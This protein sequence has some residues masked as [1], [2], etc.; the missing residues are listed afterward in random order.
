[1]VRSLRAVSD[2]VGLSTASGGADEGNSLGEF[3]DLGLSEPTLRALADME[4]EE[5]TPI[6]AQAIPLLMAGRDLVAQA[7]TGTGK[8]A[9]FGVPIVERV[10]PTKR[11]PQAIVLTP[12]R[13]L[14]VQVTDQIGKMGRLRG[15]TAV[16]IYG[17]Q[18]IG[19]QLQTL[20]RGVHVIV[21]TPGRLLDHMRR[22]S[23]D[24]TSVSMIVLDEAD[25]MLDMGF[26]EDIEFVLAA[27]PEGRVTALFSATMPDPIATLAKKHMRDPES[28][29]LSRPRGL[30]VPEID[31]VY[32]MVPFPRKQDALCR[33]LDARQPVRTM[34]FC[35]TKRMV[36]EVVEGL[37]A[38]GYLA[39]GLHGDHTQATREKVLR[40]FRS[41]RIEVLVATDVAARGLDVP[42][43]SHVVNF[44]IPPDPEYYVHRIGR[45]GRLGRSGEAITFV[46]PRQMRELKVIER[47]T[48]AH[49]RREEVPTVAEVE[50]REFQA[51]EE[52]LQASLASG[53]WGRYRSMI[54]EL[55]DEH[56]PID[57]AAAAL[58]MA[59]EKQTNDR[60]PT[61]PTGGPSESRPER[62]TRPVPPE[63]TEPRPERFGPRQQAERSDRAPDRRPRRDD[64]PV[65][66]DGPDRSERSAPYRDAEPTS[67][68][69]PASPPFIRSKFAA[70]P[71][72]KGRPPTGGGTRKPH[73]KGPPSSSRKDKKR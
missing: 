30:T 24:L 61:A 29:K 5:S 57:L 34:V 1:M 20:H 14:A 4:F 43:V 64:R 8:T 72:G 33:V 66:Q 17:G 9:A 40:T 7:L 39:D 50:E 2:A 58:A 16:P 25:Q 42:E 46:N 31:Q 54:E 38:R 44:D 51:L 56:D 12:T 3:K 69:G 37:Q 68:G 71:G 45:T 15:V 60:R 65:R 36:D 67:E 28:I 35:A 49:I 62:P 18:P 11:V 48:G 53:T 26:I 59:V 47:V 73:R 10:D 63:R 55:A 52:R 19:R 70:K 6:Q 21:A 22:G 41:G 13:E 27:L 23:V 32:Y